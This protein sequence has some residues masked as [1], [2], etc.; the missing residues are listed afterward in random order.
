MCVNGSCQ[1]LG[2]PQIS[3]APKST[4]NDIEAW[5]LNSDDGDHLL[6]HMIAILVQKSQG[7]V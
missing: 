5:A 3:F 2:K 7:Q 1:V 6:V 4:W